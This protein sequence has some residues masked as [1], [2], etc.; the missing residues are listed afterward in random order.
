M[1]SKADPRNMFMTDM[2]NRTDSPDIRVPGEQHMKYRSYR[3]LRVDTM[4]FTGLIRKRLKKGRHNEL[5][6]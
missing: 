1:K 3:D 4:S 6:W 2:R 5:H